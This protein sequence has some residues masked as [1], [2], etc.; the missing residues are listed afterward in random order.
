MRNRKITRFNSIERPHLDPQFQ[1]RMLIEQNKEVIQ[2]SKIHIEQ[3]R[4]H[5][6]LAKTSQR[7]STIEHNTRYMP[8]NVT[9]EFL[10]VQTL[11]HMVK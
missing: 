9:N 2:L 5:S 4:L 8:P 10:K 11:D 6:L 3:M 1:K 7:K